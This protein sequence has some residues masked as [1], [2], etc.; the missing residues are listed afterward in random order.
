MAEKT[1]TNLG[2]ILL[3]IGGLVVIGILAVL[4]TGDIERN[5]TGGE[6]G[7]TAD[8]ETYSSQELNFSIKHPPEMEINREGPS[9]SVAKFQMF[10]PTQE[11]ATE[12]TDGIS[13]N[14]QNSDW[15]E[16]QENIQELAEARFEDSQNDPY[17]QGVIQEPQ[18]VQF[19]GR[20]G[21]MYKLMT[22]ATS[23]TY[24]ISVDDEEYLEISYI[25]PDPTDAGFQDTVDEMLD[26]FEVIES[27][28]E[29]S[30]TT[31]NQ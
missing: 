30:T 11:E 13:L 21:Y 22:L 7:D 28:Q 23:T 8:W 9:N 18:N 24:I 2:N 14:V 1:H 29:N 12:V 10:G 26:S 15:P 6:P 17:E 3:V 5:G 27:E 31:E 25:A 4:L 19:A 16:E 20:S